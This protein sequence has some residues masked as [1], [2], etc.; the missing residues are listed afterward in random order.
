MQLFERRREDAADFDPYALPD[1]YE[2]RPAEKGGIE[3]YDELPS[4]PRPRRRRLIL[5]AVAALL[6]VAVGVVG[7]LTYEALRAPDIN[8]YADEGISIGG[9]A[10][11]DF[12]VTPAELAQLECVSIVASGTGSGGQGQSKAGA[13]AAYGPSLESFLASQGRSLSDFARIKI[14]CKDG[15]VVILRP[16]LLEDQVILSLANNK[17]ALEPYQRPLRMVIPGESTGKWAFG[18]LR[19]EFS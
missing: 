10:K 9:L 15:Y 12:I 8:S 3:A 6:V 7:L 4:R 2:K 11:A 16:E 1:P 5:A 17:N 19:M 13:V 18:V 14:Y